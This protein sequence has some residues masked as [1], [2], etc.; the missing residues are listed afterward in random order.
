MP[1]QTCKA[2]VL[3]AFWLLLLCAGVS[4][5][6]DE[7]EDETPWLDQG[8]RYVSTRADDLAGWM[9]SFF[10]V[11][12]VDAEAAYSTLRLRP[13][14]EWSEQYG[15]DTG[16]SLRGKVN[17]PNLDERVSL[18]F[19]DE[20]S[21]SL[22]DE[23][24]RDQQNQSDDVALQVVGRE[25]THD[26]IDFRLGFSSGINPEL[27]ARY[28]YQTPLSEQVSARFRQEL[29][30]RT[31]DRF[32]TDTRFDIDVAV[33]ADRLLQWYNRARWDEKRDGFGWNTGVTVNQR[34]SNNRVIGVYGTLNGRTQPRHLTQAYGMGM[35]YRQNLNRKWLFLEVQPGYF[36]RRDVL[37]D[38]R[39]GSAEIVL[40]LEAVFTGDIEEAFSR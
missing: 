5:E 9:D 23:L 18:L 17:L 27:A 8:H 20:D 24:L 34:L 38:E 7:V 30:Y 40:R 28:R 35:R 39:R 29:L 11:R 4:A 1:K 10:G 15:W 2:L 22:G 16:L 13:S 19:S 33:S 21:G 26:R 32:G 31:D 14:L 6:E 3:M 37:E 36:W 25:G 12:R